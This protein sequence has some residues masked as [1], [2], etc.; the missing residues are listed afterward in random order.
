MFGAR[1]DD[2]RLA[3]RRPGPTTRGDEQKAAFVEERE[4]GAKS[5]DLF[6][7]LATGS[8]SSG[9]SPVRRAGGHGVPVPDNSTASSATPSTRARG[10][11]VLGTPARSPWPCASRSRAR[12]G[13]HTP[14]PLAATVAARARL[15]ARSACAAGRELAWQPRPPRPPAPTPAAIGTPLPPTPAPGVQPRSSSVL[16]PGARWPGGAVFPMSWG[17]PR[18]SCPL[19]YR[20][21]FTFAKLN[22]IHD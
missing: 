10:D 18:V 20:F 13:S 8:A 6:L 5:S 9:R 1:E 14:W 19:G 4:M 12:S 7:W 22:I 17:N 11:S 15:V 16:A 21:L 3:L 2:R